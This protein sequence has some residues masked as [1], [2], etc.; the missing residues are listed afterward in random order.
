MRSTQQASRRAALGV[1][2]LLVVLGVT[3]AASDFRA[4]EPSPSAL[5]LAPSRGRVV[6]VDFWASWCAPCRES[7]PWMS[8]MLRK[9]G[10]RGLDIVAVN[11]DED[12]AAAD[13]FLAQWPAGFLIVHDPQGR[14]AADFD[15]RTMP[16]SVLFDRE[17]RPALV[18]AGF[19]A[20][21][22]GAYEKDIEALLDGTVVGR[23]V[24]PRDLVASTAA[25]AKGKVRAW[26]RGVLARR[27]MALDS[28][29]L[30][31]AFDDHVFFSKEGASGG[32]SF[33]GGGCGCN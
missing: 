21:D 14:I 9:Y 8:E 17:G 31:T 32:R 28:D 10:E 5:D 33:A 6:L 18:H 16:T 13:A 25:A 15:I 30:E 24:P 27:D 20:E 19:R 11:L 29:P 1:L 4:D 12:R 7:F 26:E 3:T 23:A 2:A 22:A